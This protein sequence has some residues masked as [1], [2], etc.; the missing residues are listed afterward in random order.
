MKDVML[1]IHPE[2]VENICTVIGEKNGKPIYKKSIEV[3]KSRP[4]IETPFRVFI[5]MTA[6]NASYPIKIDG[7]PYMCHNNG[8][9]DVIGEFVCDRIDEY[10]Y[11]LTTFEQV[12]DRRHYISKSELENTCLS[13]SEINDYLKGNKA[14]FWHISDLKIYDKPKELSEFFHAC[15]Q[16]KGTDCSQCIDRREKTCY[17]IKRPPQSWCY[18]EGE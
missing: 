5:Y 15:K 6:G 8:G 1:S 13:I 14:Y 3:R 17:S 2:H 12:Y 7:Y 18:V 9:Q 11:R 10:N 16:P 4:K